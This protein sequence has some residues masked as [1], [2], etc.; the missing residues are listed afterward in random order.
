[1][2]GLLSRGSKVRVLPG[3]PHARN[4]CGA[5]VFLA[6]RSNEAAKAGR[7]R[8]TARKVKGQT[9]KVKG[10]GA[11]VCPKAPDYPARSAVS[12]STFAARLAGTRHAIAAIAMI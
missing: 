10:S 11:P 7:A 12:G 6:R 9:S 3:A 2:T 1:M 4:A 5:E 8:Q